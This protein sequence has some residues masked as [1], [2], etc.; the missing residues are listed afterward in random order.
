MKTYSRI[1]DALVARFRKSPLSGIEGFVGKRNVYVTGYPLSGN[2]W[3]AYVIT[4]VLNCNYRDI[5]RTEWSPQRV[6]LKKY[7]CGNNSHAGTDVYDCVLKTHAL[8]TTIPASSDDTL[9][10]VVRGVYDVANSYFHRVEKIWPGSTDWKRRL[11]VWV[12]RHVI[13]FRLRYRITIRYFSRI[14]ATQVKEVLDAA[15]IPILSYEQF[16]AN[17]LETLEQ[18][19]SHIDPSAWDENVAREALEVF[20]FSNMKAAAR[21]ADA[22]DTKRTDRTGGSGDYKK[23]FSSADVK[24][25]QRKYSGILADIKSRASFRLTKPSNS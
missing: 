12:A 13:P 2:S 11:V 1:A 18:I 8:P 6:P 22:D 24:W 25:F 9:I 7:L 15:D 23:Y 10:Y 21:E 14:W 3:I 5:D 16:V 19:I 20:S 17:P 4:Y